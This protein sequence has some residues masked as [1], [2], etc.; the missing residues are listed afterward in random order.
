MLLYMSNT[1]ICTCNYVL[2]HVWMP[3]LFYTVP[4]YSQKWGK[5]LENVFSGNI[6]WAAVIISVLCIMFLII[7]KIVNKQL[8][9]IKLYK[10]LPIPIPSQLILVSIITSNV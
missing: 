6:V 3:V 10:K 9:K 2:C 1:H 5:V 8:L 4:G 7:V